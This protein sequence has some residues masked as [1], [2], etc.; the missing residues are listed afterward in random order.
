MYKL[1]SDDAHELAYL[2]CQKTLDEATERVSKTRSEISQIRKNQSPEPADLERLRG[3][4]CEAVVD[5]RRIIAVLKD[6]IE[7]LKAKQGSKT[8]L[9]Q[10]TWTVLRHRRE[11]YDSDPGPVTTF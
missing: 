2:N 3:L 10:S 11:R 8:K 5:S 9:K 6:I 1:L 7:G 4:C